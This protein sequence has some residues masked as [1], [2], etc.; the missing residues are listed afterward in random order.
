M[1][2]HC[3]EWGALKTNKVGAVKWLSPT[4]TAVTPV[5][6][7]TC[8]TGSQSAWW[9]TSATFLTKLSGDWT[10][11]GKIAFVMESQDGFKPSKVIAAGCDPSYFA[12]VA[13]T[14]MFF[15][16]PQTGGL[17]HYYGPNSSDAVR[18]TVGTYGVK[19][20]KSLA[21]KVLAPADK[22]FCYLQSLSGQFDDDADIVEL[23]VGGKNWILMVNNEGG[24]DNLV[25]TAYC[26]RLTQ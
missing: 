15:G 3:L 11:Q 8:S 7:S 19:A 6:A 21:F 12:M 1:A 10:D 23:Y 5:P 14:S 4:F 13:A 16:V 25:A 18:A 9:G 22:A 20:S 17:P 24:K 2:A 26:Y